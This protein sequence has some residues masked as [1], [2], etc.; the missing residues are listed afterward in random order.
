[1]YEKSHSAVVG[2]ALNSRTE[3]IMGAWYRVE[4]FSAICGTVHVVQ[5][6]YGIPLLLL[7]STVAV[8][9]LIQKIY[10]LQR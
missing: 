9:S 10:M 4:P 3:L 2:E 1:M 8:S 6:D 7:T 5:S